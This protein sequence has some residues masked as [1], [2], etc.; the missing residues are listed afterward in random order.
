MGRSIGIY[1]MGRAVNGARADYA[2][3]VNTRGVAILNVGSQGAR[4]FNIQLWDY[5][6]PSL[7]NVLLPKV[8]WTHKQGETAFG[9]S[10]QYFHERSLLRDTVAVERQYISRDEQSHAVSARL[11]VGRPAE[12]C[13][14]SL[15][16]TRVTAHGRFLF[17]REWGIESFI[18][19]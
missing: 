15:N 10:L 19:S 6:V 14:W 2:G 9:L 1:P 3:N 17:P 8:E 5:Y 4:N 16:F 13:D 7:F 18:R 12:H 11:S